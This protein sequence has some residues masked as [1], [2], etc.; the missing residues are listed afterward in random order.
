MYS[1]CLFCTARLGRND[2]VDHF[3]V[4]SRLGFDWDQGRLWVLCA[5]CRGWNLAPLEERWEAIESLERA[6]EDAAVG[7][8]TEHVALRRAR[9]GTMLVRIGRA[10]ESLEV[11]GW[12]YGEMIRGRWRMSRAQMAAAGGLGAGA[13]MLSGTFG[14]VPAWAGAA[15]VAL[16]LEQ[17]TLMRTADGRRISHMDR[18]ATRLVPADNG[19][20]WALQI[21]RRF[22]EPLDVDGYDA[23][24]A[25]RSFLRTDGEFRGGRD[26]VENA[27]AE[28]RRL[29][30]AR[31]VFI[32]SAED[33]ASREAMDARY[34][35]RARPHQLRYAHP[36][37][38]LALEM[39]ADQEAERIALES[40][41]ALLQREWREAEEIASIADSLALPGGLRTRLRC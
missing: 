32:E 28:S 39:A 36:V 2:I 26:Q 20:G 11:A 21:R 29:G 1:R 40:E 31:R 27:I 8:S 25:V 30:S 19:D 3:P 15:L 5:R 4:G 10:A 6:F 7:A 23:I 34:R 41:V 13:T 12:R 18:F 9:D 35:W 14:L 16:A 37:I 24:R 38:L 22:G 33:L 17:R